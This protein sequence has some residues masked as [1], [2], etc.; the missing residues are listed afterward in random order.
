MFSVQDDGNEPDVDIT[1]VVLGQPSSVHRDD[2][3]V[4]AELQRIQ[5][6]AMRARKA[7]DSLPLPPLPRVVGDDVS[8]LDVVRLYLSYPKLLWYSCKI[9]FGVSMHDWKT[10]ITG[11]VGAIAYLLSAL[12]I[13]DLSPDFQNAIIVITVTLIGWFAKDADSASGTKDSSSNVAKS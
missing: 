7:V 10:T 8:W 2:E 3:V 13:I 1:P 6:E 9:L 4:R 5:R 12:K 11:V